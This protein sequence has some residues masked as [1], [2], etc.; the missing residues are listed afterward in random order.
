MELTKIENPYENIKEEELIKLMEISDRKD[1]EELDQGE[2]IIDNFNCALK[3][4]ILLQGK[5]FITNKRIWFKSLFN[6]NTLFGKTIIM[7]PLKDIISIE[8]QSYLALD[9]SIVVETEKVSYFFTNYLSRDNCFD[10][11]QEELNKVKKTNPK[12]RKS[13]NSGLSFKEIKKDNSPS[14][15]NI[16]NK[17]SD[18]KIRNITQY[19]SK[20]LKNFNFSQKLNLITKERLNIIKKNIET[21]KI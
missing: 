8:K 11:L 15:S 3:D 17:N 12:S 21:K 13:T 14:P 7:I 16:K 18:I 2:N 9:N 5:F 1:E 20:F 19:F 4:K 6:A 10:L